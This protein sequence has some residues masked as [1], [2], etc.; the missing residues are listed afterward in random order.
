MKKALQRN[1]FKNNNS[2]SLNVL[3]KKR[4]CFIFLLMY[5]L[6]IA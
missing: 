1:A 3:F 4:S 2:A 5:T 6:D